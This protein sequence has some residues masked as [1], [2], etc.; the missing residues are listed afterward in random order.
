MTRVLIVEN[1]PDTRD[2]IV[3]FLQMNGF[4]ADACSDGITAIEMLRTCERPCALVL[5]IRMPGMDGHAVLQRMDVDEE[6]REIPVVVTTGS[7]PD[8]KRCYEYRSVKRVLV[9]PFN[10]DHLL[11]AVSDSCGEPPI[12]EAAAGR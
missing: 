5:D 7:V 11:E 6:L 4:S 2:L 3:T 8:A 9:K 10:W 12:A 1:D